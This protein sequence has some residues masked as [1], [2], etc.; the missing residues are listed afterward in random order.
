[1]AV[2]TLKGNLKVEGDIKVEYITNDTES[3][4]IKAGGVTITV[5]YVSGGERVTPTE[6]DPNAEY[7]IEDSGEYLPAEEVIGEPITAENFDDWYDLLVVF[8]EG[9]TYDIAFPTKNGTVATTDD[10]KANPTL[11]GTESALNGIEINGVKFKAGGG[12]PHL[13]KHDL[14]VEIPGNT[15]KLYITYFTSDGVNIPIENLLKVGM[16]LNGRSWG[17]ISG[18]A[19]YIIL[20]RVSNKTT[21]EWIIEGIN[22]DGIITSARINISSLPQAFQSTLITQIF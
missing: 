1:M 22:N 21:T 6:F 18:T 5:P 17:G 20:F 11:D 3:I 14:Y 8:V 9:D 2:K 15:Y 12:T 4:K 16:V 13:Y 19:P 10:V 7:Y